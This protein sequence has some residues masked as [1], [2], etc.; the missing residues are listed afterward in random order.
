MSAFFDRQSPSS[1]LVLT[2]VLDTLAEHGWDGLTAAE[3]KAR[4]GSAG[5]VLG[6]S[7]DLESLVVAALPRVDLFPQP[8]TTG[9]LHEDLRTLLAPW[10]NAP[11]RDERIVAALISPALR[12]PRLRAALHEAMDGPLNRSVAAVVAPASKGHD[13]PPGLIQTLFWVLRG[14]L[15]DR[16]RSGPRSAVNIEALVDFLVAG[17]RVEPRDDGSPRPG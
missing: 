9:D 11:D 8:R 13:L 5:P 16:L 12:R 14:L 2:A 3:V 7:P 4:A 15:L 1:G 10:R 6:D 17:L